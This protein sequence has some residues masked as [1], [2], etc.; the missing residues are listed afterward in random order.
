MA[1]GLREAMQSVLELQK[2]WT[3]HTTPDMQ[4]RGLL[5]RNRIPALLEPIADV[6]HF[7]VEGSAGAGSNSRVPWVRVFRLDMS[8]SPQKGWYAVFLFAADGGAVFLSLIQ[9]T[10]DWSGGRGKPK[11]HEVL[12]ARS[13]RARVILGQSGANVKGLSH[14]I[15]LSDPLLGR[16]YERGTVI[17]FEYRSG[18]MP[19][20]DTIIADLSQILELLDVLDTEWSE[21]TD[22]TS[23]PEVLASPSLTE[24]ANDVDSG[25]RTWIFQANPL[26]YNIVEAVNSLSS[27]SWL[28]NRYKDEIKIG[29]RVF[30]WRSGK[31][32]G[33]IARATVLSE[34]NLTAI[35][36]EELSFAVEPEKFEGPQ[37]RVRLRIEAIVR[38]TLLRDDLKADP[39]LS[40]LSIVHFSQGTN[41][42]VTQEEAAAIDELIA[43]QDA[44][45]GEIEEEQPNRVSEGTSTARTWIYAPG[46]GAEYWEEFYRDGI[47]AIGWDELGDL[48][49]YADL[50]IITSAITDVYKLGGRPV[51][52]SRACFDFVNGIQPGDRVIAKKGRSVIVGYG[53]VT[54]EYKHHPERPY[55]KNVRT[56]RWD[57]RGNWTAEGL[58]LPLKAL[59]DFTRYQDTLSQVDSILGLDQD[60][61]P[62]PPPAALPP[63]TVENALQGVV[64][65][66]REFEDILRAWHNKN[67]LILQ[68]PPGV[69]KTLLARRLAYALIG[70][71]SP[72]RVGMV[73][74]HQS[75]AYED[76]IQ[77]YRP[78]T[79][80]FER[81]DGIFVRFCNKA[82]VDQDSRYVFIIDEIN[83]GNVSKI[84]GELLM[85]IEKDYRGSQHSV[86]LT[87]SSKDDEQFY[88]PKNVFLLGMMNTADR[89]LA[90]VDYALRRRFSFASLTPLFGQAAFLRFLESA[91]TDTLLARTLSQRFSELNEEIT[92]DANLGKG[93]CVGHSYFCKQ[94]AAISAGDY[95][96][97]IRNEILPLLEEYW[98]DDR[99]RVDKWSE[100]LL[101]AI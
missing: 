58:V 26:L 35:S 5:I 29:D 16:A 17:A 1:T 59:T 13:E 73:Q 6:R 14:D 69:G 95:V 15:R 65:E 12:A 24:A 81:R 64:F 38:P 70:Y 39:R 99:E 75:Y 51:N 7:K 9:G 83:R 30:L 89:S 32:A 90:L 55:F 79:N 61:P 46:K 62:A 4:E 87:Y 84:F 88:V 53:V 28:V 21:P 101:A 71:E 60:Q 78:A 23:G 98:V 82:K 68:G 72:S 19:P 37:T 93:F 76:F 8:P 80:G 11:D 67:N 77:G 40:K 74:F 45:L 52:V 41:F 85:L 49:G 96:D 43:V 34:P 66:R 20:D 63:Y 50:E 31:D 2:H 3:A 22:I 86:A 18:A 57:G 33:I 36:E 92:E 94:G 54:G 10:T 56:V 100:R 48:S 25:A 42:E 91:G 47:M 27:M 44:E 97:V